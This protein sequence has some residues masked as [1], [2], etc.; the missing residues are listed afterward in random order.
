MIT[1]KPPPRP[2]KRE[3]Q[4]LVASV[5]DLIHFSRAH[6]IHTTRTPG[7]GVVDVWG[8][9]IGMD[10]YSWGDL[11]NAIHRAERVLQERKARE[12]LREKT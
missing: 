3:L 10:I 1:K 11:N 9:D 5:L 6:L 2:T 12:N 4:E 7:P 8:T